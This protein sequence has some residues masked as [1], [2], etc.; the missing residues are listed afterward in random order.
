MGVLLCRPGDGVWLGDERLPCA[1][2]WPCLPCAGNACV[3]CCCLSCREC[4]CLERGSWKKISAMPAAP[5]VNEMMF[6][7]CGRYLYQ[8]SGDADSIHTRSVRTGELLYAAPAGVFPRCMKRSPSGRRILCAGGAVNE[9]LLLNAPDLTTERTL[10]TRHPCF[11]ADFWRDGLVLVC[12]AEGEDIRTVV[13]TMKPKDIR[14]QTLAELPGPPCA[15]CV[16]PD[17]ATA[18]LSARMGLYRIDL[19]TGKV[20]WNRPEWALCMR[21]ECRGQTAL[22]SDTPDGSVCILH[23]NRPWEQQ[24]IARHADSQACF[25]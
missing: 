13:C 20:W 25:V 11:A 5:G 18:L 19:R 15:V 1:F 17:G 2:S 9:A 4:L 23:L 10:L 24:I 6:S 14:P 3:A 12:A 21:L 8:L 22:I 7:A 16:C